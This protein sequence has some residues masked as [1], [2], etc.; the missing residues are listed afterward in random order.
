MK[1]PGQIM[2]VWNGKYSLWVMVNRESVGKGEARIIAHIPD[3]FNGPVIAE[4]YNVVED[5]PAYLQS[6]KELYSL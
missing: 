3:E 5:K 2:A 4:L 1:E 6:I